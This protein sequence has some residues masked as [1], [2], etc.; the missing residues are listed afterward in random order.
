[1]PRKR[2]V[3]AVNRSRPPKKGQF[4]KRISA[5]LRRIGRTGKKR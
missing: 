4:L 3:G 5:N 2:R 1:M